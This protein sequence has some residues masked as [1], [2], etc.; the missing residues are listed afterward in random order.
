MK[1]TEILMAEHRN[2]EK[3]LDGVD[4]AL[5][6]AARGRFDSR[7]LD[8]ALDFFREYADRRHHGKEEER[9]F[10]AMNRR[11]MPYEGGPL[12]CMLEEHK[13]G[14][15]LLS[16]IRADLPGAQAGD[17]PCRR[18]VSENFARYSAFLREHIQKEDNIL[19]RMAG[20]MLTEEDQSALSAEFAEFDGLRIGENELV[21]ALDELAGD[22]VP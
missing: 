1:A 3:I 10:P 4:R 15:A 14:R 5:A 8:L 6:K 16:S 7:P 12:H 20:E 17:H 19:F 22:P 21:R 9:L 11:G 18:R 13:F 2:I